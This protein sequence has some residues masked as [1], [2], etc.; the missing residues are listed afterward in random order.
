[1]PLSPN[2]K[3]V[4]IY[5]ID[6][7]KFVVN[8]ADSYNITCE[9]YNG[10]KLTD[11]QVMILPITND[12]NSNVYNTQF[13]LDVDVNLFDEIRLIEASNIDTFSSGGYQTLK[14]FFKENDV[15]SMNNYGENF[16]INN[17]FN[18]GDSFTYE[19]KIGGLK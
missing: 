18:N 11:D 17:Q 12:R 4:R 2:G 5:H 19:V 13:N 14:S 9:P 1:M 16:F 8:K 10:G 7:R 6:N 15:F 3:G